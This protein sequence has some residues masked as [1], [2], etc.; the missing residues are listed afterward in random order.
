MLLLVLGCNSLFFWSW[1]Q[2]MESFIHIKPQEWLVLWPTHWA[3]ELSSTFAW[4]SSVV[5]STATLSLI[6]ALFPLIPLWFSEI[7]PEAAEGCSCSALM[8]FESGAWYFGYP[9][10]IPQSHPPYEKVYTTKK[11]ALENRTVYYYFNF[12][13]IT[14]WQLCSIYFLNSLFW[15]SGNICFETMCLIVLLGFLNGNIYLD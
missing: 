6:S 2:E 4:D 9:L 12:R 14:N 1:V 10:A 8:D 13:L 11:A 15:V 3:A 7:H 5:I